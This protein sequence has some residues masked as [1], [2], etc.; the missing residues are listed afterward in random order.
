MAINVFPLPFI[1]GPVGPT[2]PNGVSVIGPTGPAGANGTSGSQWLNN[3]GPPAP[4]L[5]KNTDYYID[6]DNGNVYEKDNGTWVAITNI[7]GP[8]GPG[9]GGGGGSGPTGPTG[10]QGIAGIAGNPGADGPTGPAGMNGATG[11]T[12]PVGASI[13]GPT[14]PIGPIGPTG[15]AGSGSNY[16]FVIEFNASAQVSGVSSLPSGWSLVSF[17][18]NS[19]VIDHNV[20]SNPRIWGIW[21]RSVPAGNIFQSRPHTALYEMEYDISIPNRIFINGISTAG[22]GTAA[23]GDAV[24]Q[25]IF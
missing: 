22:S 12:G 6:T 8:T 11:P 9:G 18:A 21:G 5:G 24:V 15:P 1:P 10:P 25:I 14:G 7:K 23:S 3:S 4:S 13:A 16:S 17:T 20:G 2:G 19:V